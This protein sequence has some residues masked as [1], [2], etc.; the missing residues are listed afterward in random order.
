MRVNISPLIEIAAGAATYALAGVYVDSLQSVYKGIALAGQIAGIVSCVVG[1]A[2]IIQRR[3]SKWFKSEVVSPM[4]NEMRGAIRDGVGSLATSVELQT[5]TIGRL[6]ARKSVAEMAEEI[7]STQ[8]EL[9]TLRA[10]LDRGKPK[11]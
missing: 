9:E 8:K 4:G 1:T 5:F 2:G 6:V 10:A 7:E 11:V 3:A